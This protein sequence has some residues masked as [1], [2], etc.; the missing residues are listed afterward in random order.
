MINRFS[1][2]F[3][4]LIFK[5][6]LTTAQGIK[7]ETDLSWNEIREKAKSDNRY[8]FLDIYA[9]WCI[10]CKKMDKY[11]YSD[12][13]VGKLVNDKFVAVKIQFDRTLKDDAHAISWYDD[14]EAILKEYH[15]SAVPTYLFFAPDGRLIKK[16]GG[17]HNIDLFIEMIN[18]AGDP[19]MIN[20]YTDLENYKHGG[21]KYES[22]LNLISKIRE[23]LDDHLFAQIVAKDYKTNYFDCL[24]I[25]NL[26]KKENLDFISNYM[27]YLNSK[28]NLFKLIQLFPTSLDSVIGQSGWSNLVKMNVITREEILSKIFTDDS[29]KE[30]VSNDPDWNLM[31]NSIS[32][33]YGKQ[34]SDLVIL[35]KIYF[36]RKNKEWRKFATAVNQKIKIYP[37]KLEASSN[38]PHST[39]GYNVNAWDV[40]LYCNDSVVLKQALNWVDLAI[41]SQGS[42]INEQYL[43]TKANILY[44]LGR[45]KDAIITEESAIDRGRQYLINKGSLREYDATEYQ[46]V[47]NKMRSGLPTWI[48][49]SSDGN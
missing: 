18:E 21:R 13:K 47:I 43:D 1:F 17:Y 11:V 7:F 6:A 14:A 3:F 41:K 38:D 33:K 25:E 16:S 46:E 2:I 39:F 5:L 28:D 34:Y 31:C 44:K 19:Q 24:S 27:Q 40:F 29:Y 32:K 9:T 22:M 48:V 12:S 26:C 36:Y 30:L 49:P 35:Q 37:P 8:I 20:F 42:D 15:V 45:V 23:V 4:Y 10:P